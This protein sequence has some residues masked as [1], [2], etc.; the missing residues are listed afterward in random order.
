MA[1]LAT[2]DLTEVLRIYHLDRG[3]EE[4]VPKLQGVGARIARVSDGI[5]D[6]EM[7]RAALQKDLNA[8]AL[9]ASETAMA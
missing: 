6:R 2:P 9:A 5:R 7:M 3:Y 1:G 4:L 8:F